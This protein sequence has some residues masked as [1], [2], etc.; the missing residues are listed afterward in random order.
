MQ[1]EKKDQD[2]SDFKKIFDELIERKKS[3]S[4][5]LEKIVRFL[6]NTKDSKKQ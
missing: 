4:S 1:V 2:S 6:N 5:A 3:Q